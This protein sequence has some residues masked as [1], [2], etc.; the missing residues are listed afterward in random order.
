MKKA[1]QAPHNEYWDK[2]LLE[3]EEKDP[4]RWRHTGYKKLY[5][6]GGNGESSGSDR[7]TQRDKFRYNGA[8][9][10]SRSPVYRRSPPRGGG[11]RRSP[12]KR[13][14]IRKPRSPVEIRRRS[15]LDNIKSAQM[16]RPLNYRTH[17]T[18]SKRPPSPPSPKARSPSVSSGS[19]DSYSGASDDNMRAPPRSR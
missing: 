16:K 5:G 15:P 7:D 12:A 2:K 6:G 8:Q 3:V 9:R 17:A 4:N 18:V 14:P 13:S 19:D 11:L 10:K 1:R